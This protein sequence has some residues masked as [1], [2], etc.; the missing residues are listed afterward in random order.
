MTSNIKTFYSPFLLFLCSEQLTEELRQETFEQKYEKRMAF[1]Q[2]LEDRLSLDMASFYT[3]LRQQLCTQR[4]STTRNTSLI[5]LAE[6]ID[7]IT[8][9]S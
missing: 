3:G 2:R 8:D 6:E 5:N 4:V 7:Q 1:L 9:V